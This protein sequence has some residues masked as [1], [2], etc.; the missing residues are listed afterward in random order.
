MPTSLPE[1]VP[2]CQTSLQIRLT[3]TQTEYGKSNAATKSG[4]LRLLRACGDLASIASSNG[5]RWWRVKRGGLCEKRIVATRNGTEG[6]IAEVVGLCYFKLEKEP[7]SKEGTVDLLAVRPDHRGAPAFCKL[8][9]RLAMSVH[10]AVK[11]AVLF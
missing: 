9:L 5:G 8:W 3:H 6:Q 10:G 1:I 2:V 7:L 11:H 4:E